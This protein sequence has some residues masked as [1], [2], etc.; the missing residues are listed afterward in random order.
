MKNQQFPD[1]REIKKRG[2]VKGNIQFSNSIPG[3]I[4]LS[5][6]LAEVQ[7]LGEDYDPAF[8]YVKFSKP[9]RHLSG[10]VELG[11]HVWSTGEK[12]FELEEKLGSHQ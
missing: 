8:G 10:G 3:K 2:G 4:E 9:I 6:H 12:S 7:V 1:E 11:I 5:L